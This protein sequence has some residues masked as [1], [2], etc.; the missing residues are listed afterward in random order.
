MLW[1]MRDGVAAPLPRSQPREAM[2]VDKRPLGPFAWTIRMTSIYAPTEQEIAQFAEHFRR[3]VVVVE[4][5]AM[6][7]KEAERRRKRGDYETLVVS[8]ADVT[9]FTRPLTRRA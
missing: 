3:P 5:L 1:P 9:W 4:T 7:S 8:W 2:R 6:A